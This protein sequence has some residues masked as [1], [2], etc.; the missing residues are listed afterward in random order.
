MKAFVTQLTIQFRGDLRDKSILMVYYLVP[1]AFYLVMASIM[2]TL[3]TDSG[4]S[5]IISI[6][7]FALSMSTYL[8]M[9]QSLVKVRENGVLEAYRVADIPAW[10]LPLSTIVISLLHIMIITCIIL[11]TAPHL[12]GAAWPESIPMHLLAV[13]LIAVCSQ[14][15]GALLACFVK[16][17]NTLTLVGQ[18]LFMPTVLL[19]GIMFPAALLPKPLQAVGEILPATQGMRLITDKGL[20]SLPLLILV[21]VTIIIFAICVVMFRHISMRA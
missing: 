8:G 13:A 19:S 16:R 6:T 14:S 15:L 21:G 10:S 20:Q 1:L 12:Y 9:P 18:C 17:Q 2:K 7:I 5:L 11:F 4:S 3:E